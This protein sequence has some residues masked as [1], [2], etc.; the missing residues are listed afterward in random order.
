MMAPAG[1]DCEHRHVRPEAMLEVV[2]QE[3]GDVLQF[4][5]DVQPRERRKADPE[6]AE[7]PARQQPS[8]LPA[9]RRR[10]LG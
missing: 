2:L 6:H 10:G 8:I 9:G 1:G 3:R 5:E 4:D 7:D